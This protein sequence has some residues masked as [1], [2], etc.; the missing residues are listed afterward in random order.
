MDADLETLLAADEDARARV[1]AARASAAAR[2]ASARTDERQRRE[3]GAEA[4]RESLARELARIDS[5]RETAIA[6]RLRARRAY[7]DTRRTAASIALAE[8]ADAF[9]AFIRGDG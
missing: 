8:A 1:E 6:S 4:A 7:S 2:M 5:D 3:R 9:A